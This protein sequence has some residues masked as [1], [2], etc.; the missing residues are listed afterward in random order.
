MAFDYDK[1]ALPFLNMKPHLT[2]INSLFSAIVAVCLV[3]TF[4]DAR[5]QSLSY[6][7]ITK[8]DLNAFPRVLTYLD[9]FGPDGM[10]IEGLRPDQVTILEN[11]QPKQPSKLTALKTPMQFI[12]A[13]N[14]SPA[15][16]IRDGNGVSR[17]QKVANH[18]TNWLDT[19][20]AENRDTYS[21]VWNG[22]VV[23]SQLGAAEWKQRLIEFDPQLN[24]STSS[25]SA[26]SY[27]LEVAQNSRSSVGVKKAIVLLSG[28][29][30]NA[31]SAALKDLLDRASS[32]KVRVFVIAADA[33]TYYP[34]A[35][36]QSLLEL[37]LATGGQYQ[38]FSGSEMLTYPEQWVGPL[39]TVYELSY[40]TELR[41]AGTVNF[42]VQ[43]N[44]N[45]VTLTSQ[46]ER[47]EIDL[48]PPQVSLLSP[49]VEI[50]RDNPKNRFDLDSFYPKDVRVSILVEYPDQKFRAIRR[51]TLFVNGQR[52]AENLTEPFNAFI[53]NIEEYKASAFHSIQVEVEDAY[54]LVSQSSA[55]PVRL[56][57]V[58]PPGGLIGKLV[59]N[60][61]V[62]IILA[63]LLIGGFT[64]RKMWLRRK[65]LPPPPPT[66]PAKRPIP[67]APKRHEPIQQAESRQTPAVLPWIAQH[68]KTLHA[69]LLPI[70]EDGSPTGGMLIALRDEMVKVG[71]D[72][73]MATVVIADR[74]VSRLHARILRN[75]AGNHVIY[76]ERSLTGTWVNYGMV[77]EEGKPLAAD[78]IV[79]FG[80]ACYR[81]VEDDEPQNQYGAK[82]ST[83]GH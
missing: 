48:K 14:A 2:P 20:P 47:F 25:L 40:E 56:V 74:S 44:A 13:I 15:L 63:A 68:A 32:A 34:T 59:G 53:W 72:P 70:N 22:G 77:H 8:P 51:S 36:I 79:N 35:G 18:L 29:L 61:W 5:G 80:N 23:A 46:L 30:S 3:F 45:G 41:Q 38:T 83:H 57:V 7:E 11:G 76:D 1:G 26:L 4:S 67:P 64:L 60:N 49:P 50:I 16:A 82:P 27:G 43:V 12:F 19:L 78:D 21:L 58:E 66:A 69:H 17:Y 65:I 33:P 28:R 54:G 55:V 37:S 62:V 81:Y 52:V 10:F 24:T 39:R 71:S 6:A 73:K 42:S 31:D 9:V 75:D